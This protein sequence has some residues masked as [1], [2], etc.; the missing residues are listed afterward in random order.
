MIQFNKPTN[1]NGTELRQELNNA[2]VTISDKKDSVS[3]DADG[4]LWLDIKT[5]D[6][7]KA[8][9]IVDN[10]NGTIVAPEPTIQ[11]KLANAGITLDE[12]KTALGL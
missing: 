7:T 9:S 1:L 12:L 3:L 6:K 8:K 10:H 2:G 4:S 11:N 5:S